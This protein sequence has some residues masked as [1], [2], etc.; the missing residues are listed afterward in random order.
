MKKIKCFIILVGFIFLLIPNDTFTCTSL[1]NQSAIKHAFKI[2]KKVA[3]PKEEI[4]RWS[5]VFDTKNFKIY[6]RSF[7]NQ[8]T[9]WIDFKNLDFNCHTPVKML[10]VHKD[11]SGDVSK[12]FIDYS[13][14]ITLEH[15]LTAVKHFRPDISEEFIKKLL[16]VV[17]NFPCKSKP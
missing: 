2:L 11:L 5:I 4:T 14:D 15:I 3:H 12:S 16:Q 9:R 13:H 10:D 7:N 8:K 1:N 6:F 17:E